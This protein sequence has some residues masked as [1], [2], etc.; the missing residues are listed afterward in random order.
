LAVAVIAAVFSVATIVDAAPRGS[1]AGGSIG[2]ISNSGRSSGSFGIIGRGNGATIGRPSAS[3][4]KTSEGGKTTGHNDRPRRPAGKPPIIVVIPPVVGTGVVTAT[5]TFGGSGPSQ[6]NN[7]A[8]PTQSNRVGL[9]A[10][11][12]RR[13]AP[14]QV[15]VRLSSTQSSQAMGALLQRHRLT[16][17][18]MLD[19]GGST[20]ALLRIPD[21]RSVPVVLRALAGEGMIAWAQ[22]NYLYT[23]QEQP[24]VEGK[25]PT[26]AGDPAQYALAKLRLPQA[27]TLAKGDKVLVAVIDS[28]IDTAHPELAGM[29]ADSFNAL[30]VPEKPHE[31]GTAIAG[32]IV[33]RSKLVGAAP[34]AR[35]LAVA[36]FGAKPNTAEGTTVNIL[37]G[38]DWAAGKGAR[39]INMSFTGPTDP[40]VERKIADVRRKGVVLVAAAGNAGPTSQ[41]L[42]PAAYPGVI[43]VTATDAEDRLFAGANRGKYIA[44]AAPGVDILLAAPDGGYQM[45][46]GTSFA[47]AEV[48][49][50]AALMLERK[51]NLGHDAV[52][53][54]LTSTAR[55]LGPRGV[56]PQFGA[57]LVDAY[58]AIMSL[59]PATT[60]A[61]IS[62]GTSRN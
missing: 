34:E 61:R 56:D 58:R 41:P 8:G 48:S 14:D 42:Y 11:N 20:L 60:G 39:I 46:T 62:A 4:G 7:N 45:K 12:E 55:D 13:Y 44:V 10:N 49:G 32:A 1:S 17:L 51:P 57:G 29:V 18:E 35:I 25:V 15:L 31:H 43:A 33:A 24:Q 16:Q 54:A 27:H 6:G 37:K 52:R 50:I 3:G 22:P 5:P 38:I 19:L 59:E 40:E 9:P 30:T 2:K 21:G 26:A 28:T 47:A 53:R 36:A 23:V